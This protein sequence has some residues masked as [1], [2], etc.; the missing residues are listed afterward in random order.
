MKLRFLSVSSILASSLLVTGCGPSGVESE[1][2]PNPGPSVMSPSGSAPSNIEEPPLTLEGT[3]L[4]VVD[5]GVQYGVDTE[6]VATGLGESQV[7]DLNLTGQIKEA[8]RDTELQNL[9]KLPEDQQNCDAITEDFGVIVPG[10]HVDGA[11]TLY[12]Q[13]EYPEGTFDPLFLAAE[14]VLEDIRK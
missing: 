13:C 9:S 11:D 7:I 4:Y 8:L 14:K 3:I 12:R 5:D 6:G 1:R 10:W 2:A